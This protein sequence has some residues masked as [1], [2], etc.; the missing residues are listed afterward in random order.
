MY[1]LRRYVLK[2][3]INK[4]HIWH[5]FLGLLFCIIGGMFGAWSYDY[6]LDQYIGNIYGPVLSPR[7]VRTP[8]IASR[9]A[10]QT[11]LE[12]SDQIVNAVYNADL[13]MTGLF[14]VTKDGHYN[15]NK[16]EAQ[17]LNLT[18]DGWV[19]TNYVLSDKNWLKDF[20][21]IDSEGRLYK[22]DRKEVDPESGTTFLH[23]EKVQ[24]L[25]VASFVRSSDL[26][27]GQILL[28]VN[29][30]QSARPNSVALTDLK[31]TA[32]KSSDVLLKEVKLLDKIDWPGQLLVVDLN[33]RV[34][35]IVKSDKQV[36]ATDYFIWKINNLFAKDK[37]AK[38]YLGVNYVNQSWEASSN[39]YIKGARLVKT[40]E[41]EAVIK[42]SPAELAGLREGDIILALDGVSLNRD[43]DLVEL[44]NDYQP[45]D[46]IVVKI[47]RDGKEKNLEVI[48]G[49]K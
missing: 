35:G 36:L 8:V 25:K 32:V 13:I 27:R 37:V 5:Y 14:Q 11:A 40:A 23:L 49:S 33:G 17:A 10:S 30:L 44:L 26:R 38:I 2:S 22:I 34:A 29:W 45:K 9:G 16:P 48:L 18:S 20:V 39:A 12:Q 19:L 24:E 42:G 15:L 31:P 28:S 4:K 6:L 21:A 43:L 47:L 46:K 1:L 7:E 3:M 41:Q